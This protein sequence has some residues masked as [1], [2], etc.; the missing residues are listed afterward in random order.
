MAAET[1]GVSVGDTIDLHLGDGTALRP[2]VAATYGRG[3]G[4]GDLTLPHDVLAEHTTT[5]LDQSI[6]VSASDVDTARRALSNMP[7]LSVVDRQGLVAAGQA[8]RDTET[9]VNLIALFVILGYVAIAVVNTLVM[10]TAARSREFALLRL[11]G[12]GRS[13]V[14]R[15]TRI[16]AFIVVGIAI[17]VGSVAALP[18]LVGMSFGMTESPVPTVAPLTYLAVVV[19][20]ALLG[21]LA[22]GIPTRMA[23][24]TRPVNALA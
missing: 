2:R 4:F 7:G 15:M 16:E 20:T 23:L 1:L 6:L 10:A 8:Q 5:R 9:W 22:I 18:P 12:S 11:V 17:V 3:L 14:R 24:R 21:L 13:Q 19:V